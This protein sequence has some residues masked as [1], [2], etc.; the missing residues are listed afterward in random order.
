LERY[1]ITHGSDRPAENL[2]DMGET[3]SKLLH[4]A[5]TEDK[6]RKEGFEQMGVLGHNIS[7]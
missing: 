3:V 7:G 2:E 6:N 1:S 5:A 4:K